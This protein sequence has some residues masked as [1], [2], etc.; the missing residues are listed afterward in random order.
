MSNNII[1]FLPMQAVLCQQY[2]SAARGLISFTQ[3]WQIEVTVHV[4]G[5]NISILETVCLVKTTV[6]KELS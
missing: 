1:D 4:W 3:G 2:V 5:S 6:C